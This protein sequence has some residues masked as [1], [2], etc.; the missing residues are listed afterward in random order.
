MFYNIIIIENNQLTLVVFL[1]VHYSNP[2]TSSVLQRV[3][4][5]LRF[6]PELE[7]FPFIGIHYYSLFFNEEPGSTVD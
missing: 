2:V 6:N 3:P 7:I 4:K 5:T 1:Q